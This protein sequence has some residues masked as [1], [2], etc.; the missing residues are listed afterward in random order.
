MRLSRLFLLASL[1][2][3]TASVRG[4]PA[5]APSHNKIPVLIIDGQNNHDWMCATAILRDILTNS[6][7]FTVDV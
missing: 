5:H 3:F 1:L 2:S 7:R 6:G 4:E